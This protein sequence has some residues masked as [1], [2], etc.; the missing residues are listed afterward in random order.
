MSINK[1]TG[2]NTNSYNLSF[3]TKQ[4]SAK[5]NYSDKI[6]DL[7]KAAEMMD[8]MDSMSYLL[9]NGIPNKVVFAYDDELTFATVRLYNQKEKCIMTAEVLDEEVE[10]ST[11]LFLRNGVKEENI[12]YWD[13]I[14]GTGEAK[15]PKKYVRP[16]EIVDI[17]ELGAQEQ[18]AV[19]RALIHSYK[20]DSEPTI[21]KAPVR[22]NDDEPKYKM[23]YYDFILRT[24]GNRFDFDKVLDNINSATANAFKKENIK[25]IIV[26]PDGT[27]MEIRAK[28]GARAFMDFNT[29]RRR[30]FG[31]KPDTTGYGTILLMDD[32][33]PVI[34]ETETRQQKRE[35]E[36]QMKKAV[37]QNESFS[38][39]LLGYLGFYKA[40]HYRN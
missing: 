17:K 31:E 9:A 35:K 22:F 38:S 28:D 24:Y 2:L 37:N 34:K 32:Y 15:L 4:Y 29:G 1:I 27:M 12:L 30:A 10:P 7:E 23:D 36:N 6:I 33:G 16:G 39:R 25:H 5:T 3:G 14:K 20:R 13:V 8:K 19:Q 26:T 21:L 11:E 18:V 40:K